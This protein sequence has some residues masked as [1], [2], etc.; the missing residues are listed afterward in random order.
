M[1]DSLIQ[2]SL[3]SL[4][5]DDYK[6]FHSKLMPGISPD[7]IIGVRT[8]IL[9]KYAKEIKSTLEAEKFLDSLPHRFYEENNLHGIL[10]EYIKEYPELIERL[11]EFLPYIDNWATCDL[12]SPKLFKT[13]LNELSADCTRWL[14]SCKPFVKRF[15]I[16]TLMN[17]FL[18]EAFED[19]YPRT[20][21]DVRSDEYY[22]N[23]AIAWYFATALAK[24]YKEIVPYLENN[25]LPTWTHN[26]TI[27]KALESFRISENTKLYLRKLKR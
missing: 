14:H 16:K 25:V 20:I 8:P 18:D 24:R 2:K 5:D 10:L 4:G 19:K 21:A 23:M 12:I 7:T 13:H 26:K 9:R 6:A 3:Y 17:Y 15:A 27:Q 1:S 11:D 22:V